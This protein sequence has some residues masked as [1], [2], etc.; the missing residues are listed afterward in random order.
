MTSAV[1]GV[2][3]PLLIVQRKTYEPAT[4]TVAV[5]LPD[6]E[7]LKVTVPGPDIFDHAPAP[8]VGV[9]PPNEPLVNVPQ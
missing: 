5:E 6:V 4:L 2:Q 3:V 9:L 7:A 8:M 1:L